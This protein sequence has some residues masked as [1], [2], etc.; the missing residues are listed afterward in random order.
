MAINLLFT[1]TTRFTDSVSFGKK[2][3]AVYPNGFDHSHNWGR[4][5]LTP[6]V[7]SFIQ[8]H[9]RHEAEV[10]EYWAKKNSVT[11]QQHVS[12]QEAEGQEGPPVAHRKGVVKARFPEPQ[13]SKKNKQEAEEAEKPEAKKGKKRS[14]QRL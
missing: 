11:N 4:P 14:S 9:D 3:S 7:H 1:R 10:A 6:E 8:S 12:G 5:M 13:A 2:H